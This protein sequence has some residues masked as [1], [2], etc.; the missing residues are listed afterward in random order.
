MIVVYLHDSQERLHLIASTP[1]DDAEAR[2]WAEKQAELFLIAFE[3]DSECQVVTTQ[4]LEKI[5]VG[6]FVMR[7]ATPA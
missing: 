2:H 6:D 1:R 3:P 5:E 4:V 7:G